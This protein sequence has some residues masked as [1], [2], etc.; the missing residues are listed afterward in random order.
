MIDF[1]YSDDFADPGKQNIPA[2]WIDYNLGQMTQAVT[3]HTKDV[4]PHSKPK[5]LMWN[6]F[7]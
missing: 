5:A 4:F 7:K 6:G 2:A 1:H 3:D